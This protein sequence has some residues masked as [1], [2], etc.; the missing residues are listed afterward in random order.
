MM[1]NEGLYNSN[2]PNRNDSWEWETGQNK[3]KESL[4]WLL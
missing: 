3:E 1:D 2:E 4:E